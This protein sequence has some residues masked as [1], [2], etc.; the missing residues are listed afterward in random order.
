MILQTMSIFLMCII[1]LWN[2]SAFDELQEEFVKD[3]DT[4]NAEVFT[5][6]NRLYVIY[7]NLVL[8]LLQVARFPINDSPA[9]NEQ[10]QEIK[11][12]S[13]NHIFKK[14]EVSKLN[15]LVSYKARHS[16]QFLL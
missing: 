3:T 4:H 15:V 11:N 16:T 10:M 8:N 14:V 1:S 2:Q 6:P 12:R 5:S 9:Q 13:L 7:H